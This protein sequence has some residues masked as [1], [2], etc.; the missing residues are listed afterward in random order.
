[1]EA[2]RSGKHGC[3]P[4]MKNHREKEVTVHQVPEREIYEG[5]IYVDDG[6]E[7]LASQKIA[8]HPLG[9]RIASSGSSREYD[10]GGPLSMSWAHWTTGSCHLGF[11]LRAVRSGTLPSHDRHRIIVIRWRLFCS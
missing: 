2:G 5:E 8:D 3:G 6:K 10:K 9:L 11:C 4:A 7:R 1:M